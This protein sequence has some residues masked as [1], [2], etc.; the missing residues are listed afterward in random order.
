MSHNRSLLLGKFQITIWNLSDS[1]LQETYFRASYPHMLILLWRIFL[2]W[3]NFN[4]F[5]RLLLDF[6]LLCLRFYIFGWSASKIC[7]V[8]M[9]MRAHSQSGLRFVVWNF[10]GCVLLCGMLFHQL[11]LLSWILIGT[12]F[13]NCI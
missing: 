4:N 13:I 9:W 11:G 10:A 12:T 2:N 8:F 3:N 7:G 6:I 5:I 1:K